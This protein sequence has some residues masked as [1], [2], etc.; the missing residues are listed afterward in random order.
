[1]PTTRSASNAK[2]SSSARVDVSSNESG[3]GSGSFTLDAGELNDELQ[4]C[5]SRVSFRLAGLRSKKHLSEPSFR[6][7]AWNPESKEESGGLAS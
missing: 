6:S 1:M 5:P 7:A 2:K 3:E 4:V